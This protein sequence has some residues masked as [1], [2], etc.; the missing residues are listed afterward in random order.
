MDCEE[1]NS[2]LILIECP[3]AKK[4]TVEKAEM[5]LSQMNVLGLASSWLVM[6]HCVLYE[7]A[8]GAELETFDYCI[9]ATPSAGLL[10]CAGQQALASLQFLE[11]ANNLTLATGVL[12]IK[13]DSNPAARILPNFLDQDPMDFR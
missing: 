3:Q 1:K 6:I 12:M 10:Q 13:D 4:K 11:D 7:R 5:I 2:D 9:R 8:S